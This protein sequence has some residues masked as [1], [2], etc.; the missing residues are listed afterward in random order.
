MPLST[1]A[2]T[3]AVPGALDLIGLA[4]SESNPA[5][6]DADQAALSIAGTAGLALELSPAV[7][8]LPG[9]GPGTFLLLV[10]NTGNT[11]D[12]YAAT[13][14]ATT[15]GTTA[16]L[17][18]LDGN[19][20]QTI[21]VFRL[22]GLATGALL[23]TAALGTGSQGT[24]T[25]Q[26]QSLSHDAL[27]ATATATLSIPA[28]QPSAGVPIPKTSGAGMSHTVIRLQVLFQ[29]AS[30]KYHSEAGVILLDADGSIGGLR[31]GDPG[32]LARAVHLGR[33]HILVPRGERPGV[34]RTLALHDGGRLLYYL[35]PDSTLATLLKVNPDNHPDGPLWAYFSEAA[36]NPDQTVHLRVRHLGK[37]TQAQVLSWEDQWR[38]GDR[39][40]NDLVLSVRLLKR[41]V[42]P[43]RL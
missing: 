15:G 36:A 20:T 39:D 5:V 18:G 13:I 26:V 2:V 41:R 42:P 6:Q 35:V 1:N 16:H 3:F 23:L 40:F 24:V 4:Q 10:H 27:V 17:L 29:S 38:G 21:P 28:P 32:F 30:A 12:S 37:G 19:P 11:E 14:T 31:P 22:P 33:R 43:S 25:I 7:Q 9:P 8:V 34:R